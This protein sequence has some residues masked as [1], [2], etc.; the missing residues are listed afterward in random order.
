MPVSHDVVGAAASE[1]EREPNSKVG[2]SLSLCIA[3]VIS[4]E[5]DEAE[6]AGIVASTRAGTPLE[7]T[8]VIGDYK[9]QF[10]QEN[11]EMGA[12]IA[13]RLLSAG[14][15]WQPLLDSDKDLQAHN[16]SGGIWLDAADA[17]PARLQ[18]ITGI[19]PPQGFA[20]IPAS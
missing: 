13:W 8:Q 20:G 16:V 18:E 17:T 1:R 15:V 11:P 14:K 5:V 10:W 7:M 3:N 2:L 12:E 6:I 9:D 4:G 19:V